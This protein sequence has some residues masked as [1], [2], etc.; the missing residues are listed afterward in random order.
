MEGSNTLSLGDRAPNFENL[1]GTDGRK[2]SLSSFD[3]RQILVFVFMG[4]GCPTCKAT[5]ERLI[6]IQDDYET[7]G[8]QVILVNPNNASLSP[9]DTLEEM[10]KRSNDANYNFPY[11]KDEGGRFALSLGAKTTPHA[12]VVDNE[13]R[14]RY[15]GRVDNARQKSMITIHDVRQVLQDMTSGRKIGTPE[16]ESF[17]CSIVW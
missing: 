5:E 9:P 2:Y 12:F 16:T 3:G 11:L 15:K 6:S 1:P 7:K 13:R 4:T 10:S 14:L 17:G 8:V